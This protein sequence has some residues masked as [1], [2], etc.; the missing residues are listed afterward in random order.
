MVLTIPLEAERL[1]WPDQAQELLEAA[2][3][4][5]HLLRAVLHQRLL[6]H[7][8]AEAEL[9]G[10]L[11]QPGTN[12][13]GVQTLVLLAGLRL[14]CK[15]TQACNDLLARAASADPGDLIRLVA[16]Q[17]RQLALSQGEGWPLEETTTAPL[18]PLE[19]LQQIQEFLLKGD[20][21]AIEAILGDWPEEL[22]SPEACELRGRALKALGHHQEAMAVLGTLL[23]R[24]PGSPAAWQ[25]VLELNHLAG[26]S[27]GLALATASRLHPRDPGIAMHRV[28]IQLTDRQP[29]LA[30]RSALLE[31]LL[32]SVGRACPS[33]HQSD[34]NLLAAYDQTGR[35]D[36]IPWLHRTLLQ[37]LPHSPPL[38]ANVTMQLASQAS[39]LYGPQ[40][41]AH[42]A[43]F[44][45]RQ[46][47][48]RRAQPRPL[49]LGL[50]SPD[51]YYH[52]VGRFVQMLLSAGFG[53]GGEL[54]L[55]NTG[56]TPSGRL[57]DLA[58]ERLHHLTG[59]PVDA[60]LE[61]VRRLE[62]D[63][64]VD[65]AGWTGE[66][67]GA[68]FAAGIAPLQV[69]YLGYF[70][71]SGLPSL[72]VWLGDAVLFPDPM[73]EWHSERIVRLPRPFLAWKPDAH[74]PEG[75]VEVPPAPAGPP[76]F[77]CFNHVRKLSAPT[78]R[79]W[80]QL[81][82]SIPGARLALKA[83][84]SDD[85]GVVA[86][87]ERRMRRC[88]LDPA[89]VIWLPTCPR[90]SD[91]LRQYG[92]ID[93]AL[94]PFPNGGCTTTCEALWMGVPVITLCGSHYV[95]RM[96]SAVLQGAGL[97]EWIAHSETAYLRL[98]QRAADQLPAI[99]RGRAALRAHLQASP[100]GDTA[101]L[102]RQL[103]HCFEQLA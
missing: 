43:T 39:P 62:L 11:V 18:S 96:A 20:R 25:A 41:E 56:R 53:E 95:G 50:I 26:R 70:A 23:D 17:R 73:Q 98:A 33:H 60:R 61:A 71:S 45:T 87:L 76:T 79:L 40:A 66:N 80:A 42:A 67:N 92:L 54:H 38:H 34:A 78:L 59:H 16:L 44:P 69:N 91:H 4:S 15:Q 46:R 6:N 27:N 89:Q 36:L 48:P 75:M 57:Q 5:E 21:M 68:L 90:P 55:V 8:Q 12:K 2:K 51:L 49:R 32:H 9:I 19:R 58:G 65:L 93:I 88:G 101:D 82:N 77:G 97:P 30:R 102:A 86:L 74:L 14:R 1:L 7:Q 3:A 10:E 100:L 94:D 37:R 13:Q 35:A 72:D 64:A 29:A 31:R 52:P 28:L 81:L 24:S 85:P 63:V 83:F 103:W 99:R 84:T 47:I 22:S